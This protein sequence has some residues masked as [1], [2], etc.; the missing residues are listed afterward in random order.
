MTLWDDSGVWRG[1]PE[2]IEKVYGGLTV[3]DMERIEGETPTALS[4]T[5][6]CNRLGL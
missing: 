2:R 5:G 4:F 3:E 6:S 1:M